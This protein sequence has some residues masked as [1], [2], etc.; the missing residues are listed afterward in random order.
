[1][2]AFDLDAKLELDADFLKEESPPTLDHDFCA[3]L[4][5]RQ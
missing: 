4:A 3:L 2:G 5:A 1:V